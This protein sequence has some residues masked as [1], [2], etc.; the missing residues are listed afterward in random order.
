MDDLI[1]RSD[2]IN[3]IMQHGKDVHCSEPIINNIY[4]MA[5]KHIVDIIKIIPTAYS[6]ENVV[7]ELEYNKEQCEKDSEYWMEHPWKD[8]DVFNEYDLCNKKAECYEESI[9]IVKRG[10]VE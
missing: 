2:V 5:H 6:V 3:L 4:E 10:G 9:D 7:A 1:R 8:R